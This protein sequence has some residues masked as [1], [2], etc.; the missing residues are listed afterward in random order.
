MSN[1]RQRRA[2]ATRGTAGAHAAGAA[3]CECLNKARDTTPARIGQTPPPHTL[4]KPDP[5]HPFPRDWTRY[6]GG[7]PPTLAP[8]GRS[9]TCAT[10]EADIHEAGFCPARRHERDRWRQAGTDLVSVLLAV[11]TRS[12]CAAVQKDG[13][14]VKRVLQVREWLGL[15]RYAPRR[16]PADVSSYLWKGVVRRGASGTLVTCSLTA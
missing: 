1:G 7:R 15:R 8:T 6:D 16:G 11:Q 5:H 12:D 2:A 9:R 14:R 3:A 4:D 10:P 13:A